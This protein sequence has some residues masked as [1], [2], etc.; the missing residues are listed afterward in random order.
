MRGDV[1]LARVD[2]DVAAGMSPSIAE[3]LPI[4]WS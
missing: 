3:D 1:V 2:G 4:A